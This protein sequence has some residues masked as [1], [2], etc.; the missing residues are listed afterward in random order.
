MVAFLQEHPG[1]GTPVAEGNDDHNIES[2][3]DTRE[4]LENLVDVAGTP[5]ETF[6]S[7]GIAGPIPDFIKYRPHARCGEGRHRRAPPGARSGCRAAARLSRSGRPEEHDRTKPPPFCIEKA[8]DAVFEF[9]KPNDATDPLADTLVVEGLENV[10]AWPN[11]ADQSGSSVCPALA[12][13]K[14]CRSGKARIL[15][16]RDGDKPGSGADKGLIAGVDHLLLEGA[17]VHITHTPPGDDA[18]SIVRIP[19]PPWRFRNC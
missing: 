3:N 4:H 19:R 17:I 12:P 11:S 15:I 7:R 5:A 16:V 1:I 8:P 9:P 10:L 2:A 6:R 14:I 13:C 18:N